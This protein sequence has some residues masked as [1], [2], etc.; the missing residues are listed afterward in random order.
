MTHGLDGPK[1][2]CAPLKKGFVLSKYIPMLEVGPARGSAC[3]RRLL[4]PPVRSA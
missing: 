2:F 3:E 1:L 4:A